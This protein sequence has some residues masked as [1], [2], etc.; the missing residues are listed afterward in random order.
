MS[1]FLFFTEDELFLQKKGL[2]E[3][4]FW[5]ALLHFWEDSVPPTNFKLIFQIVVFLSTFY[6]NFGFLLLPLVILPA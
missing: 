3:P 6:S 4:C 2:S 1:V 5:T